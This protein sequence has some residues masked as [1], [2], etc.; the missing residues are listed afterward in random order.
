[1]TLNTTFIISDKMP[2]EKWQ[3]LL[4]AKRREKR[5]SS[6]ARPGSRMSKLEKGHS[7]I[8]TVQARLPKLMHCW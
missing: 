6:P 1:M 8:Y 3:N 7:K 4:P 5:K 2:F